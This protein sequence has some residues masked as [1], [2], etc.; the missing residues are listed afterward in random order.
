MG[1]TIVIFLGPAQGCDKKK[2]EEIFV[3]DNFRF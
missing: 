2:Y 3:G 1:K